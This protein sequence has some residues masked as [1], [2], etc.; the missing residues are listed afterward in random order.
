MLG[1]PHLSAKPSLV[2]G[3]P[4]LLLFL[5][6]HVVHLSLTV[7]PHLQLLLSSTL[8]V[9][10]GTRVENMM[11]LDSRAARYALITNSSTLKSD[12]EETRRLNRNEAKNT[13]GKLFAS[14]L[15]TIRFTSSFTCDSIQY[16]VVD[17]CVA[18]P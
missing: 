15:L 3:A 8:R 2:H 10:N 14:C 11:R 1:L 18:K 12:G 16:V 5:S 7:L 4:I 9:L 6:A 13:L 17:R